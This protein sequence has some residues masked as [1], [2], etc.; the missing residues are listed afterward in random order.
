[1]EGL[2]K[3]PVRSKSSFTQIKEGKFV[4]KKLSDKSDVYFSTERSITSSEIIPEKST[5]ICSYLQNQWRLKKQH[6]A[7]DARKLATLLAHSSSSIPSSENTMQ[8]EHASGPTSSKQRK[9]D[10]S[11]SSS[12]SPSSSSR[13]GKDRNNPR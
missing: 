6:E 10:G 12:T 8:T 13:C 1:M 7:D 9:L 5:I 11:P 2:R 3:L 4:S